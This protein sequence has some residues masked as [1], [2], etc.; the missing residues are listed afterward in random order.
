[1]VVEHDQCHGL[2]DQQNRSYTALHTSIMLCL[3]CQHSNGQGSFFACSSCMLVQANPICCAAC[4]TYIIENGV[5]NSQGRS[6]AQVNKL[7]RTDS[8]NIDLLDGKAAQS[9]NVP[10]GSLHWVF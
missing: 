6:I 7:N 8:I 4:V 1:M 3:S 2:L 9:V 5:T 10:A